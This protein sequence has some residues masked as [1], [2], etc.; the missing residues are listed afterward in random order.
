MHSLTKT[1][2]SEWKHRKDLSDHLYRRVPPQTGFVRI[3]PHP[4]EFCCARDN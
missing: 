3:E 4:P 2:K 1:L